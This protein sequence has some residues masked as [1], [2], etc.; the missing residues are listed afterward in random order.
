MSAIRLSKRHRE[1]LTRALQILEHGLPDEDSQY[2]HA[3]R[4]GAVRAIL[5][6]VLGLPWKP[7]VGAKH[8]EAPD[9]RPA[10]QP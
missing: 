5:E 2:R 8:T 9:D 7:G 3:E 6:D 10:V 4:C 1:R